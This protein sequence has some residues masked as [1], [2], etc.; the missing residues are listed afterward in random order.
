ML[1]EQIFA[2]FTSIRIRFFCQ[3]LL[4]YNLMVILRLLWY[5]EIYEH[6]SKYTSQKLL[7]TFLK[8][9]R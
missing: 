2:I 4:Q 6:F 3:K 9:M 8:A 7:T 5:I 1:V